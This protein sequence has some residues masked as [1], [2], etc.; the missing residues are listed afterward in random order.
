M[1]AVVPAGHRLARAEVDLRS[2]R[3][4]AVSPD[5]AAPKFRQDPAEVNDAMRWRGSNPAFQNLPFNELIQGSGKQDDAGSSSITGSSLRIRGMAA[6]RSVRHFIQFAAIFLG[7]LSDMSFSIAICSCWC[8]P[9][10]KDNIPGEFGAK[11]DF[12]HRRAVC[13]A[14]V[15]AGICSGVPAE[16]GLAKGG[17]GCRVESRWRGWR[18]RAQGC[19][20]DRPGHAEA[21]GQSF[22]RAAGRR[23]PRLA[24]ARQCRQRYKPR[25]PCRRHGA[26]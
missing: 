25:R 14:W 10:R 20:P 15:A 12:R 18:R 16:R 9:I 21:S 5:K 26:E 11:G 2:A 13:R 8:H 6:R 3:S 4:S 22:L 1:I 19:F 24:G 7:K 17:I 23:R